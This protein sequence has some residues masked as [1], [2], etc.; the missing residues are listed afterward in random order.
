MLLTPGAISSSTLMSLHHFVFAFTRKHSSKVSGHLL[1]STQFKPVK[2]WL[3]KWVSFPRTDFEGIT[4]VFMYARHGHFHDTVK[5]GRDLWTILQLLLATQH[6]TSSLIDGADVW[7][8]VTKHTELIN[9]WI[10]EIR[11]ERIANISNMLIK[12]A[13]VITNIFR[14]FLQNGWW[15]ETANMLKHKKHHTLPYDYR[16]VQTLS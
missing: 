15:P 1:N 7:S 11:S 13:T 4:R 16:S 9:F 12:N 3:K 5:A 8:V 10:Q 14:N 6:A 2:I